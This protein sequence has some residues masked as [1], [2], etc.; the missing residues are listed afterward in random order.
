MT[1][2][3]QRFW[4]FAIRVYH[5][6]D[7]LDGVEDSRP[8]T[9]Y[10]TK[11]LLAKLISGIAIGI[12]SFNQF[13]SAI[14][15][16]DFDGIGGRNRPSA[17]TIERRLA[18][19]ELS[20]L[21]RILDAIVQ[22]ARYNRSLGQTRVAGYRVVAIDGTGV[23]TTRSERLGHEGHFRQDVH[24]ETTDQAL[25]LEHALA[26][27]Y[28]SADGPNLILDLVRIPKGQGETTT[29]RQVM[30][31]LFQRLCR[32]CD[33]VTV[34]SLYAQ[35]PFINEVVRQHK[36]IVVRVKQ[37][38]YNIIQD[39]DRLFARQ[40]PHEQYTGIKLRK[41]S[42]VAFDLEIWDDENFT[43][44]EQ[45]DCPLRCLKL[46]ETRHTLNAAGEVLRSESIITHLVTTCP[47]NTTPALAIW[48]I[49]HRRWD[50]ENTGFHFLKHHFQLEHAYSY[51]PR[52]IQAMLRLFAITF[53]LFQ[54][55]VG[56]NLRSPVKR[57]K[58]TLL[59]VMRQLYKGLV[60]L[61]AECT[62][63]RRENSTIAVAA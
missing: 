16:G 19:L 33:I 54:L 10:A 59:A 34:D 36:D 26:V 41:E 3:M 38:N 18:S 50:I 47:K 29:A 27:S 46:R 17:D 11:D 25:Y 20:E 7:L 56:R 57:E 52:V 30:A 55:F 63:S 5:L 14:Q 60:L 51:K 37:E 62:R 12:P 48:E 24:G 4:D 44:W 39:A 21:A 2:H 61:A 49:A 43:S 6:D 28:V 45:V 1:N 23:F 53:N 58:L 22:A 32:F 31:D 9:R 15:D 35:A 8:N 40:Q 42:S 13:E